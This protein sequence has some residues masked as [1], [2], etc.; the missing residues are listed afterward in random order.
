[1]KRSDPEAVSDLGQLDLERSGSAE[2]RNVFRDVMASV[3]TPVAVVTAL[4]GARPHGTT[5]SA[6]ASLSISPLMLLVSL[7]RESDLLKIVSATGRFG[8]NVL[9]ADQKDLAQRFARKGNTKFAGVDWLSDSA[10]PR[11]AGAIGWVACDVAG[12][13]D[14]GDHE[15]VIGRVTDADCWVGAPL[16]YW[17]REF[18]THVPSSVASG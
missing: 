18:G 11:I 17:K 12:T 7:D 9:S 4:D 5:V 16:T 10:L 3:C 2:L 1:M 15:V 14:G 8:I 13:T 6:F